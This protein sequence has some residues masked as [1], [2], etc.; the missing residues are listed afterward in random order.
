[1]NTGAPSL[2]VT[3]LPAL[4]SAIVAGGVAY[5]TLRSAVSRFYKERWFDRRIDAYTG[6]IH[7]L[8][9]MLVQDKADEKYLIE[10]HVYPPNEDGKRYVRYYE[11]VAFIRKHEVLGTILFS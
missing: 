10:Q 8:H 9:D 7:A 1:M 5:L 2:L 11:C 6:A 4:I 3:V